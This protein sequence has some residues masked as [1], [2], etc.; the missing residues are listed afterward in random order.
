MQTETLI[1]GGGLAGLFLAWQLEQKGQDYHLIESRERLGGRIHAHSNTTQKT[2]ANY[3][4][5]PS[6]FWPN[7]PR[8]VQLIKQL[9]LE[10][11]EQY[12]EGG[13]LFEDEMGNV[14]QGNGY[15][16][17]QGSYRLVGS[18]KTLITHIQS[19]I[20][21][22]RYKLNCHASEIKQLKSSIAVYTTTN[23][24]DSIND[25]Y[26]E[27]K[28]LVLAIPPRIAEETLS[29]TPTL[30]KGVISAMQGIPTWMAGHAKVVAIYEHA[31]WREAG[32]S[33]DAMSHRGPLVEIH[34]ASP[35]EQGPYALFGFM[36]IPVH[37]RADKQQELIDASI[38]QL[39]RLFGEQARLPLDVVIKDWAFEPQTATVRD[40]TLPNHHPNYGLPN[41]LNT[42]W[43]GNIILSSTEAAPHYGG[44]IEGALEAAEL[45][46]KKLGYD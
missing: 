33:G 6:W 23:S 4:I 21:I 1:V 9:D 38:A 36:G 28:K 14:Q 42:I 12:A 35:K 44:Y 43:N 27:C 31:F 29:Y 5:G 30:N 8:I 2:P 41:V 24:A 11:F 39:V 22:E 20:P 18:L 32:L 26:I 19:Q 15:A 46:L 17:M 10:Y 16:S 45:T 3:D 40:H 37:A 13:L 25:K 34:D 7:Q